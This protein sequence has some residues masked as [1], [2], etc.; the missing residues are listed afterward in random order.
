MKLGI[1]IGLYVFQVALFSSE[2]NK[3]PESSAGAQF[4]Q[5]APEEEE[6]LIVF[7]EG[8][9]NDDEFL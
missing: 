2:V 1:I 4:S 6:E 9:F 5:D 7:E 3:A 8:D